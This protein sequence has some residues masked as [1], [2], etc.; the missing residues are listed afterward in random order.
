VQIEYLPPYL[1]DF[2][3][4]E[5]VFSKIKSFIHRHQSYYHKGEH[6]DRFLSD[7]FEVMDIITPEDAEGYYIHAGYF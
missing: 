4:I 6:G 5:E 7:M 2:S 1:P 3:L